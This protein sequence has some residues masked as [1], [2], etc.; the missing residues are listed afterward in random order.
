MSVRSV[1]GDALDTMRRTA[2]TRS[3]LGRFPWAG[4]WE[5]TCR[6]NLRCVMCYTDCFNTS[7]HVRQELATEDIVRILDELQEAGCVELTFTG[8]EP[9]SR[10]DFLTIYG[11]AHERGF[12]LTVFTNG[13]LITPAVADC[14]ALARP[15]SVE[16]S[17]H[18]VSA[19]VFDGVTRVPGSLERCLAGIELVMRRRIPVVLKTVGLISNWHE[20]LA[21]KQFVDSLGGATWRFGQYL[22][23]DL[24][25]T[26]AP[27]QFQLPEA[28]LRTLE[29]QD[30]ELWEAKCGE[31]AWSESIAHKTCGGGQLTFHIDAY[32]QLQLCSNNRR[33]GYDLRAGSFRAGFDEVLPTLPCQGRT[34]TH[35]ETMPLHVTRPRRTA[36]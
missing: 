27:F 25:G 10:P 23:D 20:I 9:L 29:Q 26:S 19:R 33:G 13:T 6:C 11:A 16:I 5:L 30:R 8:G 22:R 12:V 21:I 15:R 34:R 7:A 31:I 32:G 4:Q 18:G 17:V 14:W 24:A 2:M 36:S 35:P 1:P 28:R 3:L